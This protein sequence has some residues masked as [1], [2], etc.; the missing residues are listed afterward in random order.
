MCQPVHTSDK[1]IKRE[2]E[3]SRSVGG[4]VSGNENSVVVFRASALRG[5]RRQGRADN[6]IHAHYDVIVPCQAAQTARCLVL[7]NT[8]GAKSNNICLQ[9]ILDN[10]LPVYCGVVLGR[11]GCS[12]GVVRTRTVK[13]WCFAVEGSEKEQRQGR[14]GQCDSCTLQ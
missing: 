12:G 4:I 14:A 8:G 6:A 2:R 11:S 3:L 5:A 13:S 9:D 7:S 1:A 10:Y